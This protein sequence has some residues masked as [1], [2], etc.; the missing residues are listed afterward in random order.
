MILNV[1]NESKRKSSLVDFVFIMDESKM[2]GKEGEVLHINIP[3]LHIL[4]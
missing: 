2:T 4:Y 1:Q 3:L